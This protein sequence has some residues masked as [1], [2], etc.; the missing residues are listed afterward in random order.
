MAEKNK[1]SPVMQQYVDM[2]SENPDAL[3]MFRLGDFYEAFFEDAKTV[4]E[5]L[6]LVLT[7]RGTD[8]FGENVPMCGIPW[9]AADNYFGRLVRAGFKVALVEQ[10]ET[11]QQAKQRGHKFIERKVV[12][13]LTPGTITDENLLTPKNSNFLVSVVPVSASKFDIAG[14]DISTGEI[15]F[16]KSDSIID[17]MIRINPAEII[18]PEQSAENA[19]IKNLR[20]I[21]KTTPVYEKLYMRSDIN[22]I[23]SHVF[24][25][26]IKSDNRENVCATTLM[27]GYLFNTQ[28]G[29]NISFQTPYNFKS[30]RQLLIDSATWKSLEIDSSINEGGTCLL[31]VIDKTITASGA[32]KLRS[33]LRTLPGDR[34][35]ILL[36]QQH[37]G[38]LLLNHGLMAEINSALS[39]VPDVNRAIS[40]LL[41]GRGTP[42]DMRNVSEFLMVLDLIKCVGEK[43]DYELSQKFANINTHDDFAVE[44]KSALSDELPTFFRDGNVIRDGFNVALDNMRNLSNGA[45]GTIAQLQAKYIADTNINTL[46]IKFNNILGYFIEVPSTRADALMA[47]ES[48]FIHRQT[49]TG[50]MRFTTEQLIELDNDI[51]SASEK[52]SAIESEIINELIEKIRDISDD[53]MNTADL[54]ADLDVWLSLAGCA[55]LYS[56]VRPE[57]TENTEFNIVGGR[58]PVIEYVLHQKGDNF[59]KNDCNLDDKS[60]A[61]L[62]G[63]NMA[64]KSTYLRQNAILVVLAHLGSFVPATSAVIGICD[65]LFSRVGASDNLAAG[66]STFMVEMVETS[67][68]LNRATK[69]SFIIFDEIGRGTSTF[70]GMA[71]AQAILE[72]VNN[73]KPRTLFATHYH[74]LTALV[75]DENLTNVCCLTIDVREHN[76]DIVFLH[77][78]IPGIA[79]RSYGIA[80]AK[81]AGMPKH[82]VE[83]AE[84][85]LNHLECG[86]VQNSSETAAKTSVKPVVEKKNN[87]QL[88]LFG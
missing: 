71:I 1:L 34:D 22:L 59:V 78:I 2:K 84:Q 11:P 88:S 79:N 24:G 81:M 52:A 86:T 45:M 65:Q 18:Y 57:I 75:S 15:F 39:R 8:G 29:A 46:K 7:H 44:L 82:I 31:D 53:L 64:G 4:S 56:W 70:D 69:K 25:G 80:V 62:T 33:Y 28:R 21:Y 12:R 20:E 19:V 38:H 41:S 5:T 68:I 77:K 49:M 87:N 30:G 43:L 54:V 47:P 37:I 32:R 61:L 6:N 67:N 72:Y 76:N 13:V 85:V 55:D 9:H 26:N 10:M 36:R 23:V 14:C 74:E 63:P 58:H 17:D 50:N 73:I 83:R 42:R 35:I 51:R 60:V 3:L 16:G 48:G 27:A 66:Q 40:R